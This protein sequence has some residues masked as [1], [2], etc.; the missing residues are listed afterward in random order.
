VTRVQKIDY[1][2]L[3]KYWLETVNWIDGN[4]FDMFRHL[5]NIQTKKSSKLVYFDLKLQR[6][7]IV[8]LEIRQ[9]LNI[10]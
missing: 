2:D 6:L 4:S 9:A 1:H 5:T 3:Y 10:Y 8:I 7:K